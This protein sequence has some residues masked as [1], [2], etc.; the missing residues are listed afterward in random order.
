MA[1]KYA[2]V[3]LIIG[4][5]NFLL[6]TSTMLVVN[7]KNIYQNTIKMHKTMQTL[8][9]ATKMCTG[10]TIDKSNAKVCRATREQIQSSSRRVSSFKDSSELLNI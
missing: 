8:L 4:V 9:L 7:V 5:M 6:I 2:S 1:F 3:R 10:F